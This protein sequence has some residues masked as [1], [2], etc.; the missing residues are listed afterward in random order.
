MIADVGDNISL[1]PGPPTGPSFLITITVPFDIL[2]AS[3][4][5]KHF[6][7]ELKTLWNI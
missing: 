4:A 1:I 5:L 3:I 6:S 2:P 7:S